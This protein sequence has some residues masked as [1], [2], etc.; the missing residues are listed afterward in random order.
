M[1]KPENGQLK[2]SYMSEG[3]SREFTEP[4]EVREGVQIVMTATP[5]KGYVVDKWTYNGTPVEVSK[6]APN[7]YRFVVKEAATIAVSFKKDVRMCVVSYSA[8]NGTVSCATSKGTELASGS[9][10]D[11]GTNLVFTAKPNSGY[12]FGKWVVNEKDNAEKGTTLNIT[13][14]EDL[15]VTA[16]FVKQQA[17]AKAVISFSATDGGKI[18]SAFLKSGDKQIEVKSGDEVPVDSVVVFYT[19]NNDANI[20]FFKGWRVNGEVK[21]QYQQY[22]PLMYTVLD[23]KNEI[24]AEYDKIPAEGFKVTYAGNEGGTIQGVY[25]NWTKGIKDQK[26]NSGDV[27][28]ANSSLKFD[29]QPKS[30][31]RVVSWIVNGQEFPGHNLTQWSYTSNPV[32][33]NVVFDQIKNYK[34]EYS[35]EH[36]TVSAYYWGDDKVDVPTGSTVKEDTEVTFQASPEAGYRVKSWIVND[37][38]IPAMASNRNQ[39][40]EKITQNTVV[41][42]VCE[43]LPQKYTITLKK[44]EN[45]SLKAG[46]L[47]EKDNYQNF[48][49]KAEIEA[50]S[51]VTVEAVP[52]KGYQVDGWTYNGKAVEKQEGS[53]PN[54]YQFEVKEA[55]TI[56]AKFIPITY[57]VTYSAGENGSLICTKSDKAVVASNSKVEA[58]QKLTFTATP[59]EGFVISKWV[60]NG[61]EKGVKDETLVETVNADLDV[62]VEFAKKPEVKKFTV[63]YSAGEGGDVSCTKSDKTVVASASLVEEGSVIVF[64]AKAKEGYEFGKWIVNGKESEV[65]EASLTQ[66]V[67][68]DLVVKAE[69]NKVVKMY[70]VTYSS[71][72][73]AKGKLSAVDTKTN[74]PV[75]SGSRVEENTELKFTVTLSGDPM[76]I[77]GKWVVDGKDIENS[78]SVNEQT[79]SIKKDT[80]VKVVMM[81][82]TSSE[83]VA[84]NA[85]KAYIANDNLVIEGVGQAVR[86]ALYT[87]DGRLVFV[88]NVEGTTNVSNLASGVYFLRLMDKSF[89][90]IKQ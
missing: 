41:K 86:V 47:D 78:K 63:T 34:V 13:A 14:T 12:V 69:F 61:T 4:T 17:G 20:Y 39:Y 51:K 49:D 59:N 62:K 54:F 55:A 79:I 83:S 66:T 7:L 1:T 42:A 27:I 87:A 11:E 16:M 56:A 48:L 50:G 76:W 18:S 60:V 58:G 8:E 36:C 72:N 46:Y 29:A 38:E 90:L 24:I 84:G 53:D 2:A 30:G 74:K 25:S 32:N 77:V 37:K 71:D 10:V 9:K 68:A 57:T 65:K 5:D 85:V 35:G 33:V 23:G 80:D 3:T 81:N 75:A 31:Y 26:F 73:E 52:A 89:K 70:T 28:P 44:V 64:M 22:L 15:V 82:I 43:V 45:G 19:Q 40:T 67:S 6:D 21:N 88:R